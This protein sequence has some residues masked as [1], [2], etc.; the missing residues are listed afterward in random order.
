M[1]PAGDVS[2]VHAF[3][4]AVR[5]ASHPLAGV[6]QDANGNFYGT[7]EFGGNQDSGAAWRVSASGVFSLLHGFM[8]SAL[9]GNKPYAGLLFAHNALYAVTYQDGSGSGTF[10]AISKLDLAAGQLPVELSASATDIQVGDSVT[11]TW[12]APAGYTCTKR[13]GAGTLVPWTGDAGE[14]GSQAVTPPAGFYTFG[15]SCVEP[16]DGN[17]ATTAIVRAAYVTIAIT[18]PALDPVDGGGGVGSLSLGWLL[19]AAA[20]LLFKVTRETR[21]TCP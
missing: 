15:L 14:S 4:G 17:T 13:H 12:S 9:D 21:R 7:S 5:G 2:V 18:A 10:G 1:T 20:L 16:D 19:L 8:G 3:T 6:I 11:L